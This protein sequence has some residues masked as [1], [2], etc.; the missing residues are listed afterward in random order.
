MKVI[1][2][3]RIL[4]TGVTGQVGG[5]LVKHLSGFEI[6][7]CG[8]KKGDNVD[9]VLDLLATE[10]IIPTLNSLKPEIILHPAAFTQ[11][12]LAE[13]NQSD[14]DAIN[15]L[16]VREI[17]KYARKN[18]VPVILFS[19]DYVYNSSGSS[20]MSENEPLNPQNFYGLSKKNGEQVL[21][22]SGCPLIIL[23]TSWVFCHDGANFLNSMLKL[24]KDR[25]ALSIVSDQIG[26]P[27]SASFLAEMTKTILTSSP[28]AE[29][30]IKTNQGIYNLAN[31]EYCSWRD[32]AVTIFEF[33]RSRGA[34]LAIREVNEIPT[35]DYP[36]PAK[37]PLNSRLNCQK[38][39]D[40][41]GV[42]RI[43]W[44]DA[45]AQEMD[46]KFRLD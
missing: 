23:R 46:K 15:H 18:D 5:A 26:S 40:T 2:M 34:E 14:A 24:G 8:S 44:K 1:E 4:V 21:L 38:F 9:H 33:A 32:F 12:D 19:T 16:A 20:P 17:G 43:S 22:D 6:L 39:D 41:F 13:T 37:R 11:V 28:T 7:R 25:D 36:T 30:S 3:N 27:T 31:S 42:R 35:S 29:E 10:K 45:L